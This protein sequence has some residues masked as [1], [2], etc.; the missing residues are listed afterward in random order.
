MIIP[1]LR[2]PL[3]SGAGN[4]YTLPPYYA[5]IEEVQVSHFYR[6]LII[7]FKSSFCVIPLNWNGTIE[8]KK[9]YRLTEN[10]P[11]S[12]NLYS[13]NVLPPLRNVQ[14][15]HRTFSTLTTKT[16]VL[17][18]TKPLPMADKA[19]IVTTEILRSSNRTT[20]IPQWPHR[21]VRSL[22]WKKISARTVNLS[23]LLFYPG[24][25]RNSSKQL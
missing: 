2:T 8:K 12:Q 4:G 17:T 1:L 10:P 23:V 9:D 24:T 13:R 6:F 5:P 11:E 16:E 22:W 7:W 19:T 21:V 3:G 18:S 25:P 20:T 14:G 15:R